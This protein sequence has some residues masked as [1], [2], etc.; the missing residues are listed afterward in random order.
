MSDSGVEGGGRGWKA[1]EGRG[2][3]VDGIS[4]WV[5]ALVGMIVKAVGGCYDE[6]DNL[7]NHLPGR[8]ARR[9]CQGS[10]RTW[11]LSQPLAAMNSVA[12]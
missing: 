4:Q 6:R 12:R 3:R 1:V 10:A 5:V 7:D 9:G 11:N 2:V 8:A